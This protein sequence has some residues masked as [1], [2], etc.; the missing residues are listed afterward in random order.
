MSMPQTFSGRIFLTFAGILALAM[1]AFGSYVERRVSDFHHEEAHRRLHTAAELLA[2][3]SKQILLGTLSPEELTRSN[4]ILLDDGDLRL[5]VIDGDGQVVLDTVATLPLENHGARPEVTSARKNRIG[6]AERR[7]ATT[8]IA[9]FYLARRLDGSSGE[10]LGFVRVA[11]KLD[12]MARDIGAVRNA[13]WITGA[14]AIAGALIGSW[15]FSRFLAR[16]LVAIQR[17]AAQIVSG[18]SKP[19][20]EEVGPI[21]VRR[22]AESINAMS[23]NL[24]E[25]LETLRRQSSEME[26]VLRS[27]GEGVV[28]VGPD[29]RVL[30]MNDA[31]A[32]LLGL[33]APLGAGEE[34]WRHCRFPELEQAIR[35]VLKGEASWHGDANIQGSILTVSASQVHPTAGAVAIL[36]DVTSIRRLEQVRIDFVANVSHE[37][38]TPLAAVLGALE[39]LSDARPGDEDHDRFLAIARRNAER[40]QSIVSDLL[41]LSHIEA[42]G[43]QIPLAPTSIEMPVRASAGA[44]AGEAEAKGVALSVGRSPDSGLRI[45]GNEKRLEQIFTNLIGNAIKYTPR[46][47]SINVDFTTDDDEIVVSVADTGI[48]IP[49][50]KLPRVFERFF[51]VD[52]GRSREMGGTGLGLAIVKHA[53]RAHGARVEVTSEEGHGTTFRVA[54]PRVRG[55]RRQ[56]A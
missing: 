39:T 51:R 13:M 49:S 28:A 37:M 21:E 38:R 56:T 27:M 46:G 26:A 44:L 40:M 54:F 5:T 34:L 53:A 33:P 43:D 18:T 6:T 15:F 42:E 30:M 10:P 32:Q 24:E 22:L 4:P 2:D 35:A 50:D 41:E 16:P 23:E 25:R 14:L 3:E 45:L 31:A 48:G 47:G 19:P 36:T 9:T 55:G 7:S 12:A 8:R 20:I 17:S 11:M 1:L 52:K 29:E